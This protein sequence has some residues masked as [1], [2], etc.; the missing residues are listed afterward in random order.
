MKRLEEYCKQL[1]EKANDAE[2]FYNLKSELAF[3][4]DAIDITSAETRYHSFRRD[5]FGLARYGYLTLGDITIL[6]D[7]ASD[8]L[9]ETIRR[10]CDE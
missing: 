10:L 1:S 7:Y 3:I 4:E 5:I 6:Y 9:D 2:L 8:L